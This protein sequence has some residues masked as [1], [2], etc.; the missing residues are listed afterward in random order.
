MISPNQ[1]LSL[2]QPIAWADGRL[3]FPSDIA[4]L[5][6]NNQFTNAPD[7]R[8]IFN[9][10]SLGDLLS[11]KCEDSM[12][13]GGSVVDLSPLKREFMESGSSTMY[14]DMPRLS[15]MSNM[16]DNPL[17]ADRW[18]AAMT[19]VINTPARL[20]ATA[21]GTP[22]LQAQLNQLYKAGA[23]MDPNYVETDNFDNSKPSVVLKATVNAVCPYPYEHPTENPVSMAVT[24]SINSGTVRMAQIN[25]AASLSPIAYVMAN[26]GIVVEIPLVLISTPRFNR[27]LPFQDLSEIEGADPT[28]LD[29]QIV[30]DIDPEW[31]TLPIIHV[32]QRRDISKSQ[33]LSLPY[34]PY[35]GGGV[36]WSRP[37][38]ADF[39]DISLE[40]ERGTTS[41]PQMVTLLQRINIIK[42]EK[43]M[44]GSD[45][46]SLANYY[47]II[48]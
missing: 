40:V 27:P 2:H 32:A 31:A 23:V 18:R 4:F 13:L 20:A 41:D 11:G 19:D 35:M 22:T 39:T 48:Q 1:L 8:V 33:S 30:Y 46:M 36:R 47:P 38:T 45:A 37:I 9:P 3:L 25:L 12:V 28:A 16:S 44:K 5:V 15:L 17:A 10:L 42:M 43:G 29:V 34:A 7:N 14:I 24:T 21:S 6:Q 26:S